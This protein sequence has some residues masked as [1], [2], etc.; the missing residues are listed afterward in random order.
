MEKLIEEDV[1]LSQYRV[2][3]RSKTTFKTDSE[4]I[5]VWPGQ[6]PEVVAERIAAGYGATVE[7]VELVQ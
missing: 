5:D 6:T 2:V 7:S 4:I 3:L 1:V